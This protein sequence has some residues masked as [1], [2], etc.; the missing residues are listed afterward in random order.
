ME[1]IEPS[2]V[3]EIVRRFGKHGKAAAFAYLLFILIYAPCVAALAAI[4]REI[5]MRWMLLATS[6]LSL[7]AW[8]VST[9]YYQLA[10]F[11]ANPAAAAGWLGFCAAIIG[12]S[13]I[14]LRVAGKRSSA[15]D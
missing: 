14:G 11:A 7:L 3:S 15:T 10:T 9:I 4:Y 1:E 8:V 12:T 6:Y 13:Y 2:Q 5:G